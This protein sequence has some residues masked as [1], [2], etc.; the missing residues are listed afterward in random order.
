M[1]WR[2]TRGRRKP[3]IFG[4]LSGFG[5]ENGLHAAGLSIALLRAASLN[6]AFL[7]NRA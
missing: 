1:V 2:K 7:H 4:E 5:I 3:A 6:G